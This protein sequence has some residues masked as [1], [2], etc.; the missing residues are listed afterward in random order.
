[1]ARELFG[2]ALATGFE[3]L[4]DRSILDGFSVEIGIKTITSLARP[5]DRDDADGDHAPGLLNPGDLCR[6]V[7]PAAPD[8]IQEHLLALMLARARF[9]S[10]PLIQA[11]DFVGEPVGI[12]T[13]DLP[14]KSCVVFLIYQWPV[15]SE[16]RYEPMGADGDG[17]GLQ[18]GERRH[19]G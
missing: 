2:S 4:T 8:P 11:I 19:A 5:R 16:S 10:F 17:K 14:I 15:C 7:A 12:R 1:M 13:R 3:W 18:P 9:A 6:G